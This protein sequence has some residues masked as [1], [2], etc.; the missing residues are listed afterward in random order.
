MNQQFYYKFFDCKRDFLVL[1]TRPVSQAITPFI[2]FKNI[3]VKS[4]FQ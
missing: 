3:I 2:N 1:L 4:L